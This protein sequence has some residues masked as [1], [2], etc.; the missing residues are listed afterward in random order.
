MTAYALSNFATCLGIKV[1]CACRIPLTKASFNLL[2]ISLLGGSAVSTDPCSP[3]TCGSSSGGRG[4]GALLLNVFH[5]LELE[6]TIYSDGAGGSSGYGGGSGG[7]IWS[8]AATYEGHGYLYAR[9]GAGSC[10]YNRHHGCPGRY[11]G[12]GGGGLIRSYSPLVV[13]AGNSYFMIHCKGCS[14]AELL[15]DTV[16]ESFRFSP[17]ELDHR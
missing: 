2:L 3:T 14:S 10:Y 6:G 9:G 13:S 16:G 1:S 11:A 5:I 17:E 8:D 15:W 12:G 7:S 4:G